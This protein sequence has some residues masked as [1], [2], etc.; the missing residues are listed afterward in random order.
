MFASYNKKVVTSGNSGEQSL[1]SSMLLLLIQDINLQM[2]HLV[3]FTGTL[4]SH[5]HVTFC[6][7]MLASYAAHQ[8]NYQDFHH[9]L[10]C[11]LLCFQFII[12]Q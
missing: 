12:F 5:L 4:S 3:A 9:Y 6:L 10:Q 1:I 7:V 11:D 8:L 2:L